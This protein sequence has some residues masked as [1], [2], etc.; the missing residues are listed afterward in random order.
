EPRRVAGHPGRAAGVDRVEL[1]AGLLDVQL[2]SHVGVAVGEV[3]RGVGD[4]LGHGVVVAGRP[5]VEVGL[6]RGGRRR[7]VVPH[8]DDGAVD[9]RAQQDDADERH[10]A[11]AARHR[12]ATLASRAVAARTLSGRP[13]MLGRMAE[14]P[15]GGADDRVTGLRPPRWSFPLFTPRLRV[16]VG[17][18]LALAGAAVAPLVLAPRPAAWLPLALVVGVALSNLVHEAAHAWAASRLGYEV[19]WVVLGG[20]SGVTAYVGRGDRPLERAAVALAGP[21]ASAAL[22]L[23]CAGLRAVAPG[24]ALA[25]AAE[26]G[27]GLNALSLVANLVPVGGTD[28][29]RLVLGLAEHRRRRAAT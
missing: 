15:P 25:M 16:G 23:V 7:R 22:V 27:A 9:A 3:A 6:D 2:V 21:A 13:G 12:R 29:A 19:A 28:G 18:A 26:V 1:V 4:Q 5:G 24:T 11:V 14:T 20:L 8:E 10:E 17:M